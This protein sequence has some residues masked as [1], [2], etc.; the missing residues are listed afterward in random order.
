MASLGS[1]QALRFCKTLTTCSLFIFKLTEQIINIVHLG[2]LPELVVSE[3]TRFFLSNEGVI[4]RSSFF[5][6]L[7]NVGQKLRV[8]V[9]GGT[10]RVRAT[11]LHGEVLEHFFDR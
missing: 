5:E 3:L 4:L 9:P 11:Y 1:Q 6:A 8:V 7:R 2:G 10:A